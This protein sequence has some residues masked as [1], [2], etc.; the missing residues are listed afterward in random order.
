MTD[1]TWWLS[2]A[3]SAERLGVSLYI[4]NSMI[5]ARQLE[6]IRLGGRIVLRAVDVERLRAE[7]Q[8]VES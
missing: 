3:A 7:L 4:L 6:T 2:K 1:D 5:A 8:S